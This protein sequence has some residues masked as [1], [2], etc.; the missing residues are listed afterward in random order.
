MVIFDIQDIG[1]RYYTYI[2]TMTY[3]MEACSEKKI[4]LFILDRPN[5]IGG[6]VDGP[7]LD[8]EF[9]SF[10]GMHPIPISH[11]M[12][13]GELAFMINELKWHGDKFVD[14]NIIKMQGWNHGMYFENTGKNWISPSPN[15]PDNQTAFLY[16]GACLL[17]GTNISEGRGTDMPFKYI[18]APWIDSSALISQLKQLDLGGVSFREVSFIPKYIPGKSTNPKFKN[19]ICNGVEIV[20]YDRSKVSPVSIFIHIIDIIANLHKKEFKFIETNFIDKLYGS[21]QL[22]EHILDDEDINSLIDDWSIEI[23]NFKQLSAPFLI[24][25]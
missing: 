20:V 7:I 24:Y 19:Q 23:H 15:I 2:S 12:T 5:P 4:P 8:K 14:L 17:E 25:E 10:V 18:G 9:S 6:K 22:R 1:S 11:G 13:I 3:I 21:N 16:Q